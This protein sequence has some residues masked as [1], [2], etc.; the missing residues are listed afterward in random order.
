[1]SLTVS[2]HY[3]IEDVEGKILGALQSAGVDTD[4]LTVDDL[5]MTDAFHIRGRESTT[6]LAELAGVSGASSVIDVGCGIGG[7]SRFLADRFGC[8]VSGFRCWILDVRWKDV[9]N[10]SR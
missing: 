2:D 3:T 1:M 8:Q 5:A 7:T 10:A 4:N 9:W 6:E